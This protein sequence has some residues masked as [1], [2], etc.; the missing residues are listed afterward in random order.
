[1]PYIDKETRK[2]F[3]KQ[4]DEILKEIS[5]HP[6][7]KRDGIL[8]YIFTKLLLGSFPKINY[9]VYER[10]IGVLECCKLEMY[11]RKVAEYENEKAKQHGDV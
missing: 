2:T 4:I 9:Q 11:R 8:N 1:M 7:E 5:K 10:M 3:E 6:E